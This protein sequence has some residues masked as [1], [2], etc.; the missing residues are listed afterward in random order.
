MRGALILAAIGLL[1]PAAFAADPPPP[2][3][4]ADEDRAPSVLPPAALPEVTV[5]AP[6]PR[7]VA[8]TLRD[9]IGRI[10]APVFINGE[11]PFRLVLDTGASRSAVTAKVA[12]ALGIPIE[13]SSRVTLHGVTGS[14]SAATIRAERL[15]VGE[16]LVERPLL[17]IVEDAFGGAEGVLATEGLKDKRITIEFR[18]D[19]IEIARSHGQRAPGGYATVPVKLSRGRVLTTD[20]RVGPL[21]IKA[22]IDTGAQQ[23]IGNLALR[24]RLLAW[25]SRLAEQEQ[26]VVGVTGD[27]QR[28]PNLAVPPIGIGEVSIS[29]GRITFVDLHIF[30][31]WGFVD[32]P[33][34][35]IGMD[36]LGLLDTLIIDYRRKELQVLTRGGALR[37]R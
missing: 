14:G 21:R 2:A 10:W 31:H 26:G 27:V 15:E 32:E 11:G 4:P 9:R 12:E 23:T 22:I 25:R 17:L 36:V 3:A 28:G 19:R 29:N 37:S 5:A 30:R 35:M 13:E 20:A 16:L 6:E 7:Y 8:P 24:E 18:R 34:L 1:C 33:V